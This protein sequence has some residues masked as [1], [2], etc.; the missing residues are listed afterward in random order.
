MS[1]N[2]NGV[3]YLHML[4]DSNFKKKRAQL[5]SMVETTHKNRLQMPGGTMVNILQIATRSKT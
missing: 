1:S 5:D 2:T 3:L 4:I